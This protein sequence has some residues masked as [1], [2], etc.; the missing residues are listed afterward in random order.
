MSAVGTQSYPSRLMAA[1]NGR[2][3]MRTGISP[4]EVAKER[5]SVP[6]VWVM[7]GLPGRPGK[8]CRSPFREDRKA[9]FSIYREGRK[10]KDHS[11]GEGGDVADFLAAACTLSPEAAC[12]KLI[13]LAGGMPSFPQFPQIQ[14]EEKRKGDDLSERA[15]KREAWPTFETPTD[16]ELRA[17]AELRGLSAEGVAIAAERR[18]LFCAD[19]REG[20]A[21]IVTDA[22]RRNAQARRMDGRPWERIQAKAWT[23]PGSEAALPIG[24]REASSFPAIA[25]VEGGP[26]LL[27]ALHLAWCA[28]MEERMAVV[29]ILGAGNR[30]PAS[31]LPAFAGKRVRVFAHA[32]KAGQSAGAA[33][34]AQ[35]IAAGADVDGFSFAGLSRADGGAVKDLN[36]FALV[37]VDHWEAERYPIEE[38]F[39]AIAMGHAGKE[40][41]K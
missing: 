33:W 27:A 23:L 8:S 14:R 10:W 37:D 38:A 16:A 5:L 15:R 30:I 6:A 22:R 7:L 1:G 18:L 13:E 3:A 4:L 39:A 40:G 29:A 12:R 24:L 2:R 19:S 34:S 35:L 17:I 31:S 9:S 11:T 28:G 25:L 26:D 36:D 41:V 20:R 32:D 21:W